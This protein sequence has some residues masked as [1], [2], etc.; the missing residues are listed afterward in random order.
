[1]FLNQIHGNTVI[2]DAICCSFLKLKENTQIHSV[3]K[4]Y[5]NGKKAMQLNSLNIS[6]TLLYL[7]FPGLCR[8][9]KAYG[10]TVA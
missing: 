10:R 1:M 9:C 4:I 2:V 6:K 3:N 5:I 7:M 8:V